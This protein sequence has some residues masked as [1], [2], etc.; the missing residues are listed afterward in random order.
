MT[1]KA[2]ENFTIT[3]APPGGHPDA[4]EGLTPTLA[5]AEL[6]EELDQPDAVPADQPDENE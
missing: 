3:D 4:D 2:D 1:P 5:E 6:P